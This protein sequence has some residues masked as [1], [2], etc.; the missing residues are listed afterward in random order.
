MSVAVSSK[1]YAQAIFAIAMESHAL[2][3]WQNNLLKITE[4]MQNDEFSSLMEN[5]K[6]RFEKKSTLI[7]AVLG[8]INPLA[9]NLAYLLVLKNKFKYAGQ[10]ADQYIS[11]VDECKG[12]KK[13]DVITSIPLDDMEKRKLVDRLEKLVESKLRVEFEVDI[14]IIGGF[15][16][17]IN[18][19]LL[20]GSISNKL[21]ILRN[22]ISLIRK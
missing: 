8:K 5:P 19:T 2:D 3:E 17:R 12:I 9:R 10:I 20:D 4:L 16:A 1:R 7:D 15:V 18:G 14:N 11:L 21:A 6:L 22:N 13:A